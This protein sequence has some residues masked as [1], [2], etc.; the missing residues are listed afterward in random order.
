MST[1]RKLVFTSL[2]LVALPII[3]ILA[4]YAEAASET[5]AAAEVSLTETA[6]PG[7]AATPNTAE[8]LSVLASPQENRAAQVQKSPDMYPELVKVA[9]S[10][11]HSIP[12]RWKALTMA[13]QIKRE[14]SIKD[15]EK[16]LAHKDW[17]MRNAALIAMK[18]VSPA[19]GQE[20]AL[21][22][23]GDRA[24]VIRSAAVKAM[25][26]DE[27]PQIRKR[28]WSELNQPYNFRKTQSLWVRSEIVTK[29]A[30]NPLP[31]EMSMF[32]K[33]LKENDE[34]LH[35]PAISALEK[36]SHRKLGSERSTVSE[37]RNLW[38]DW[39]NKNGVSR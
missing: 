8:T 7:N 13:A 12:M 30:V 34:R 35:S 25:E 36:V 26:K 39:T 9:F 3:V 38:L 2:G 16:A 5:P 18:E 29:L 24:L 33:A 20:A 19:K 11:K 4:F 28:L 31:S 23:L 27:D 15:L 10:E 6:A 21:H 32:V 37:L 22:L 14:G 1:R 17:F